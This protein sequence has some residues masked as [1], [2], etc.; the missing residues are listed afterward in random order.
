MRPRE[1]PGTLTD[2][3]LDIAPEALVALARKQ[4]CH[5]IVFA[6]NEPTV[7]LPTLGRVSE[8]ARAA[9][10]PMGCLTNGYATPEATALLGTIFSFINVSLK[11]L[12][13]RFCGDSL[14]IADSAPVV[15]NIRELAGRCH[16]E[17]T[18]PVIDGENDHELDQMAEIIA[19]IDPDIPWHV[20]RL[21]PDPQDERARISQHRGHQQPAGKTTRSAAVS[22]FP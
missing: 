18:T 2:I 8:A 9:G 21:L 10:I 6:I 11:G 13:S 12:S 1:D 7:S 4:G 19:A 3:L 20:F 15:R 14:G 16:V 5:S 17:V 22:L